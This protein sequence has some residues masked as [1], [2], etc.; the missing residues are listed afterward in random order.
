MASA[1][2]WN[3]F[4][5]RA[6]KFELKTE[7]KKIPLDIYPMIIDTLE[8]SFLLLISALTVVLIHRIWSDSK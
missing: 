4:K 1:E 7:E 5:K 6:D 8:I 2:S 3:R